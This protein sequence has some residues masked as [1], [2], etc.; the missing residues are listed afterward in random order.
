MYVFTCPWVVGKGSGEKDSEGVG[1]SV[2][3]MSVGTAYRFKWGHQVSWRKWPLS[4]DWKED[5][6][7]PDL[8]FWRDRREYWLPCAM[9]NEPKSSSVSPTPG[10]RQRNEK[11]HLGMET[12][13]KRAL[14]EFLPGRRPA[15]RHRPSAGSKRLHACASLLRWGHSWCPHCSRL[16]PQSVSR[17]WSDSSVFTPA[18]R[19]TE[20]VFSR[21]RPAC[22]WGEGEPG[23]HLCSWFIAK[24][25]R[26][27]KPDTAEKGR[28]LSER[29]RHSRERQWMV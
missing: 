8:D 14:D 26:L 11:A 13:A 9:S 4:K 25:S 5:T 19:L 3:K 22:G 27:C 7:L 24:A 6:F 18:Q 23:R 15:R 20:P 17:S 10:L 16:V 28:L 21:P 1:Y 2:Y 12:G 29:D